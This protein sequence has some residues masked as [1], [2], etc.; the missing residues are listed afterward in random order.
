[1]LLRRDVLLAEAVPRRLGVSDV[2]E[3]QPR[4]EEVHD[5]LDKPFLLH[6]A[7]LNG[8]AKRTVRAVVAEVESAV[9]ARERRGERVLCVL[10]LR[11]DVSGMY[12]YDRQR[13]QSHP[14]A[15][16]LRRLV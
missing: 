11:P 8:R 5:W 9:D 13:N 10:V 7:A 15:F 1:M 6:L 3:Q 12:L 16:L 14:A 2:S 4:R